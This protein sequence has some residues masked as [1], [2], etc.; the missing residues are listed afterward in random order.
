[1]VRIGLPV[2]FEPGDQALLIDAMH[3]DKSRAAQAAGL[4]GLDER[5]LLLRGV[6]QASAPIGF[7]N[8]FIHISHSGRIYDGYDPDRANPYAAS[9]GPRL[10]GNVNPFC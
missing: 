9:F 2:L 3:R 5:L 8:H 4:V 7:H 6:A 10:L 1:M